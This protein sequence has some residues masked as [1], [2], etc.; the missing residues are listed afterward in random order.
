[1]IAP[2]LNGVRQRLS[3]ALFPSVQGHHSVIYLPGLQFQ[4]ILLVADFSF[5]LTI[6]F[7]K[8]GQSVSFRPVLMLLFFFFPRLCQI[9]LLSSYHIEG[10]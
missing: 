9:Y 2:N 8:H 10:F 7:K 5:H 1:M 6:N 4:F 3:V